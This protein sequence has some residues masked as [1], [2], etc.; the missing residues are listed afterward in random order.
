MR[1]PE[2]TAL[3][4]RKPQGEIVIESFPTT[5]KK[6]AKFLK[7]PVIRGVFN[8]IDSMVLGMK[9]L[10]RSAEISGLEEAEEEMRRE[11]EAKKAAKAAKIAETKAE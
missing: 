9:C 4:V 3:A 11:K 10:T 8:Y 5:T 1:G 7:W 2:V 6:R